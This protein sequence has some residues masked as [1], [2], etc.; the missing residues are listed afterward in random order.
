LFVIP[1]PR[2]FEGAKHRP[3]RRTHEPVVLGILKFLSKG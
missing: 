2:N 1:S 3:V